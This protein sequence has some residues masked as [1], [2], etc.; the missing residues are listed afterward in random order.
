MLAE[1]NQAKD[2]LRKK[3]GEAALMN[4]TVPE[5]DYTVPT[6]TSRGDAF[7][8][9]TVSNGCLSGFHLFWDEEFKTS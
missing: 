1:V 9:V 6:E 3:F 8:K 2:F 7:M 5:G 4:N